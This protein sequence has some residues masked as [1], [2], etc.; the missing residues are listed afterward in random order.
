MKEKTMTT[1]WTL[2]PT[3]ALLAILS[4]LLALPATA[5]PPG[6]GGG[7]GGGGNGDPEICDDG[8]DNDGDGKTDCADRDCRNDPACDGGG[9]GGGSME[10]PAFVSEINGSGI[11]IVNFD[12]SL[13]EELI[14]DDGVRRHAPFWSPDGTRI[15]F[16][17]GRPETEHAGDAD[18]YEMVKQGD[19]SW[20]ARVLLHDFGADG[21]WNWYERFDWS[22]DGSRIVYQKGDGNHSELRVLHLA[23][24]SIDVIPTG[25]EISEHPT[26]APDLD[27]ITAGYQG[28]VAFSGLTSGEY[29]ADPDLYD[30]YTIDVS[31]D[32]QDALTT[33]VVT[34]LTGGGAVDQQDPLVDPTST[35][36]EQ[37]IAY[38]DEAFD[39]HVVVT[40][41]S[42][43]ITSTTEMPNPDFR[44][45]EGTW[46][47]DGEH[48]AGTDHQPRVRG[49]GGG[50]EIF[51][52]RADGT[53]A[54]RTLVTGD[55]NL[56]LL[57]ADWNPAW[58]ANGP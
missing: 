35:D 25:V 38:F 13:S 1:I 23:S 54:E 4:T 51:R 48:L 18:L 29:G 55:T 40:V 47:P 44:R 14:P 6:G 24:G 19:G 56:W 10:N 57:D 42:G 9:G 36:V 30:V 53:D 34:Q 41:T 15:G 52:M 27:S 7:G 32:A 8:I 46:S 26:W 31:I 20:S 22:P 43:L 58:D 16:L 5:K 21:Y 17:Q 28:Q 37:R 33:G 49:Q 50:Q 39:H 45:R 11:A 12:G 2:R 3:L